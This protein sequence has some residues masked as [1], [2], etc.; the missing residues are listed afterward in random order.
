MVIYFIVGLIF[1]FR[2]NLLVWL[3]SIAVSAIMTVESI[4]FKHKA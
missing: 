1:D 3:V 4:A 2:G